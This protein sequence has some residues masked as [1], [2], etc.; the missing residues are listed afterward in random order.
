MLR[1]ASL[2]KV[3]SVCEKCKEVTE[4]HIFLDGSFTVKDIFI[5]SAGLDE[6]I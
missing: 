1:K 4:D 5:V 3:A 6:L 2:N